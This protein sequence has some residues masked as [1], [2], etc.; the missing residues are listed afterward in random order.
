MREFE[1]LIEKLT[2]ISGLQM[3]IDDNNSVTLEYGDLMI[4]LQFRDECQ[5]ILFL[6]EISDGYKYLNL[7]R[8]L[9]RHAL[10]LS[11]AGIGTYGNFLGLLKDELVLSKSVSITN[12]SAEALAKHLLAF[13]KNASTV[14]DELINKMQ[15]EEIAY[16]KDSSQQYDI[17]AAL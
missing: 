4:T 2:R 7:S 8:Q 16:D 5:D 11:F 1:G 10:K 6:S 13:A 12:L 15:D 14:R 17:T 9:F 3:E